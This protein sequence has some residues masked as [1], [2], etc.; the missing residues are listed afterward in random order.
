M[1]LHEYQSKVLFSEYGIPVPQG[2]VAYSE[3]DARNA[4]AR[5]GGEI[6]V[7]KAQVHAGGRG[8]AGGVRVARTIGEVS[9]HAK[10][11]LGTFLVTHQSAENGLPVDCV[12]IE[13]GLAIDQ[14]FYLGV[15]VDRLREC[16]MVMASAAGGVDIEEVAETSPEKIIYG[17]VSS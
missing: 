14:E 3:Q 15:L 6:W 1:N 12:Y 11:M 8:K 10:A 2:F 5:L 7:V 9:D 4:A 17:E 13:Q 16:V